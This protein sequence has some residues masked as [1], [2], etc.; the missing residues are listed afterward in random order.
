MIRLNDEE[1]HRACTG[2][3]AGTY[4]KRYSDFIKASKSGK[5]RLEK[6][7]VMRAIMIST[8][9]VVLMMKSKRIWHIGSSD[10]FHHSFPSNSF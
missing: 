8:I 9:M 4:V 10:K 7:D 1:Q 5:T 2:N 3:Y 6:N